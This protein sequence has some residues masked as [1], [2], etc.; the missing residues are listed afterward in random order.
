ERVGLVRVVDDDV[1]RLTRVD[2]LEAARDAA[3]RL[4]ATPDRV[5]VTAHRARRQRRPERVLEVEA[6]AELEVDT[7]ERRRVG[8]VERD[9]VRELLREPPPVHVPRVENCDRSRL[10]EE[11]TPLRLKV[12]LHVAVEVEVILAEVRED[13]DTEAHAVE[14][15]ED[16]RMR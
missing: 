13:E 3:Y 14:A 15:M 2:R 8:G 4:E 16:G 1:E 5:V 9:C 10:L 12:R 6:A 11:E 7:G